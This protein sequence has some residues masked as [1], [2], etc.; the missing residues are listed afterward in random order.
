MKKLM[1]K[2]VI[3]SKTYFS[4]LLKFFENRSANRYYILRADLYAP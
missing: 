2:K 1:N 3:K 4:M